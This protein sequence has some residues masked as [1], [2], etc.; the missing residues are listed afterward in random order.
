MLDNYEFLDP[1]R[2]GVIGWSHGGLHALMNIFEHPDAYAVAYAGVPV[3][4][5]VARMG[6]KTQRYRDLYSADFHIGKTA[7]ED[8][9]EY[10]RRSPSW[11]AHKYQGTPLLIHT[12]TNDEDVNVLEVERIIQALEAEGKTGFEYKIYQDAP[13]GHSFN[14][15]DTKAA[16]ESRREI[17]R[18]PRATTSTRPIRRLRPVRPAADSLRPRAR[19]PASG[20]RA[21]TSF[22]DRLDRH[23]LDA[24]QP[25]R[26]G[27]RVVFVERLDGLDV[28][29]FAPRLLIG[30]QESHRRSRRLRL[31]RQSFGD[32]PPR[33]R[34]A[35]GACGVSVLRSSS[36]PLSTFEI[37]RSSLAM[38][39]R[40]RFTRSATWT[41]AW[42]RAASY[43]GWS[44][45]SAYGGAH[46]LIPSVERPQRADQARGGQE[47]TA[48]PGVDLAIKALHLAG[49]RRLVQDAV[50]AD[51]AAHHRS[52]GQYRSVIDMQRG[53][54]SRNCR[55]GTPAPSAATPRL[56]RRIRCPHLSPRGSKLKCTT[57]EPTSE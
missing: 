29:V 51:V 21:Q 34:S 10:K 53:R 18:F 52:R 22:F 46:M 33:W 23:R 7:Y 38:I 14:R 17:W 44:T 19:P 9:E 30:D 50:G 26:R 12:T 45:T 41:I 56:R 11:N 20:R 5:L 27:R 55:P 2:V 32:L 39:F 4:D 3:G 15:L 13:G 6:Y 16:K 35:C 31:V 57:P 37:E 1:D 42:A 24:P 8:V 40:S 49:R 43:S 28:G 36:A 47:L 48:Q 54:R 25:L